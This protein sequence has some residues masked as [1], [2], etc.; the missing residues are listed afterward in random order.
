[1]EDDARVPPRR[2]CALAQ[3]AI[4][5]RGVTSVGRVAGASWHRYERGEER[6][7]D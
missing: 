4:E 5:L 3:L 6:A 7:E 2:T 1:M